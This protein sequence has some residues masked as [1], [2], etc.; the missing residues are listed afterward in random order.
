[1]LAS[2]P[3]QATN[4][5]LLNLVLSINPEGDW[6]WTGGHQ[7][8][9]DQWVWL[10]GSKITYFNWAEGEPNDA[11]TDEDYLIFNYGGLFGVWSDDTPVKFRR[12]S[13][14]QYDP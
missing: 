7:D 13:F 1:M 3:D 4:D 14:C 10:D 8:S 2:I 5:F 12:S 9:N 11:G 6:T